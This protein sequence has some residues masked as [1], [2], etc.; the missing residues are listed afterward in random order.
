[1]FNTGSLLYQGIQ[2]ASSSVKLL[3]CMHMEIIV[4]KHIHML[5]E[6]GQSNLALSDPVHSLHE[7]THIHG[8]MFVYTNTKIYKLI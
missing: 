5:F 3:A 6:L 4:D 8:C 1:M 7:F 2:F